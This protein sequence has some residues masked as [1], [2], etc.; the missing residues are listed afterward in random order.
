MFTGQG[1]C[2]MNADLTQKAPKWFTVRRKRIAMRGR[3]L[4]IIYFTYILI[5]FFFFD[6]HY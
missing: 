4:F 2:Y 5:I 1:A 6:F 3:S